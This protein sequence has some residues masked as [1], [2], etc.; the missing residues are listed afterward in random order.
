MTSL[1]VCVC[2]YSFFQT[3][4]QHQQLHKRLT[5]LTTEA[6][7]LASAD[8]EVAAVSVFNVF[9]SVVMN[10]DNCDMVI[11]TLTLAGRAHR[12]I[13]GFSPQYFKVSRS[14]SRLLSTVKVIRL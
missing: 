8:F 14:R 13:D 5:K 3:H 1:C 6:E 7:M 9:D 11:R 4:P 12:G 2:V 10:M